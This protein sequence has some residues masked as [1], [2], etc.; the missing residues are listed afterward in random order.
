MAL[1]TLFRR[2]RKSRAA[3]ELIPIPVI[4]EIDNDVV[5]GVVAV[6]MHELAGA[7]GKLTAFL[8]MFQ[9]KLQSGRIGPAM[10]FLGRKD[11]AAPELLSFKSGRNPRRNISDA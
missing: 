10:M 4:G 11:L 1:Y 8:M 3:T 5:L 7:V 6:L 9:K 2:R